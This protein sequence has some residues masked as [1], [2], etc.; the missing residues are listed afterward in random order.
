MWNEISQVSIFWLTMACV[1]RDWDK[2]IYR[3][4][5]SLGTPRLESAFCISYSRFVINS[6]TFMK[7]IHEEIICCPFWL[8]MVIGFCSSFFVRLMP[9][10]CIW[11][12][13]FPH[14]LLFCEC[15]SPKDRW[16][17]MRMTLPSWV[18]QIQLRENLT[19]ISDHWTRKELLPYFCTYR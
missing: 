10:N 18:T 2:R 15:H 11:H 12:L 5:Q 17:W 1:S 13:N 6:L 7:W 8:M 14:V 19:T 3:S 9:L 4:F 16:H